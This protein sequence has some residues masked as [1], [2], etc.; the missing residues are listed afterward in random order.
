MV[1]YELYAIMGHVMPWPC[2][3]FFE[4]FQTTYIDLN[5]ALELQ[6]WQGL[7]SHELDILS[8]TFLMRV[9]SFK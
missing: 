7:L 9:M 6:V 8:I 5:K 1:V 4:L 3:T 2:R